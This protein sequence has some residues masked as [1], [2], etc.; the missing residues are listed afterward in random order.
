MT[1]W[2]GVLLPLSVAAL[3]SAPLPG[4]TQPNATPPATPSAGAPA[5][6]PEP[7][8]APAE[9]GTGVA[10]SAAQVQALPAGGGNR[11]EASADGESV[12]PWPIDVVDFGARGGRL[13]PETKVA[14]AFCTAAA[15][16]GGGSVE[17]LVAGGEVP[18]LLRPPAGQDGAN[19]FAVELSRSSAVGGGEWRGAACLLRRDAQ[20]RATESP[21]LVLYP[22]ESGYACAPFGGQVRVSERVEGVAVQVEVR[23]SDATLTTRTLERGLNDAPGG[24]WRFRGG[25][26]PLSQEAL[27]AC[28]SDGRGAR[29]AVVAKKT[30]LV[31]CEQ[32]QRLV[33]RPSG[34][35]PSR[36][37][38]NLE[39]DDGAH[40][41][42]AWD[43]QVGTRLARTVTLG[44]GVWRPF[45][46]SENY[47]APVPGT[48]GRP[49]LRAGWL[50]KEGEFGGLSGKLPFDPDPNP[51]SATTQY[52]YF[53]APSKRTLQEASSALGRPT[54]AG[55]SERSLGGTV[56]PEVIELFSILAEIA[57][58]QG[59]ARAMS[60]L[61]DRVTVLV[62]EDLTSTEM[63]ARLRRELGF[64]GPDIRLLPETCAVVRDMSFDDLAGAGESV[65]RALTA[66]LLAFGL[67]VMNV[68][69]AEFI[70]DGALRARLEARI[71]PALA[72]MKGLVIGLVTGREQLSREQSQLLLIELARADWSGLLDDAAPKEQRATL[73]GLELAF[74]VVGLCVEQGGCDA[75]EI[76]GLVRNPHAVF[77]QDPVCRDV[78]T[79]PATS[80]LPAILDAWPDLERFILVGLQVAVRG[81]DE[82]PVDTAQAAVDLLFDLL[83]R[84]IAAELDL[85]I[86]EEKGVLVQA[87]RNLQDPA[88]WV[89]WHLLPALVEVGTPV[90]GKAD[91]PGTEAGKAARE[92]AQEAQTLLASVLTAI[93]SQTA[94]PEVQALADLGVGAG[95][96]L[97][98]LKK[99][100]LP[101]PPR[102][103][104]EPEAAN[105]RQP[106]ILAG[107]LRARPP[108]GSSRSDVVA[109]VLEAARAA[110]EATSTELQARLLA[111]NGSLAALPVAS[112]QAGYRTAVGRWT[113]AAQTTQPDLLKPWS[114]A[115]L[116]AASAALGGAQ[117]QKAPGLA[118]PEALLT[119]FEACA[120]LCA[121]PDRATC[122]EQIALDLPKSGPLLVA[123]LR[124][125]A[126]TLSEE[127][128]R[129][130]DTSKRGTSR[131]EAADEKTASLRDA[132]RQVE[133]LIAATA[134]DEWQVGYDAMLHA[135][136]SRV[137]IARAVHK[138]RNGGP[139]QDSTITSDL[140]RLVLLRRQLPAV[141]EDVRSLVQGG[142]D[143]DGGA[144]VV[145]ASSLI[146]SSIE[147]GVL[148]ARSPWKDF[149]RPCDGIE[150]VNAC[151]R[152]I[153][154]KARK[155]ARL[156][157]TP[158]E[159]LRRTLPAKLRGPEHW[160]RLRRAAK[161]QTFRRPK[162]TRVATSMAKLSALLGAI[163]TYSATYVQ[164]DL[165]AEAARAA[166]K[167]AVTAL[168]K[169]STKRRHRA[170][171][172]I[173]SVGASA[174][175]GVAGAQFVFNHEFD[176]TPRPMYGQLLLPMGLALQRLPHQVAFTRPGGDDGYRRLS[177]RGGRNLGAGLH[178][179]VSA[180]DLGQFVA[181]APL[182]SCETEG[183]RS[184]FGGQLCGAGASQVAEPRWE[185]LFAL[186]GQVGL[187]VG[188]PEGPVLVGVD[189][190][191]AP[192]LFSASPE[193]RDVAGAFRIGGMLS[194][195]IPFF[196]FN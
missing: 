74:G 38:I 39:G 19:P 183:P 27:H 53:E 116:K 78:M 125:V 185:N 56:P 108:R 179:M 114:R 196:D 101:E 186:G 135:L 97:E 155:L 161:E 151:E 7:G 20:N 94:A 48:E 191:Y 36:T 174:G 104:G 45:L 189:F 85:R 50:G 24:L 146:F 129:A 13:A 11:C 153:E 120:T 68:R 166:R 136:R 150:D 142:L 165:D 25:H 137:R 194:F 73:C 60:V 99:L 98:A 43:R 82:D 170:A 17:V 167:D 152:A 51:A 16:L 130:S 123:E 83:Q 175:I 122:L 58:E 143:Q 10:V 106:E 159:D 178:L 154:E 65:Y 144:V 26:G 34:Q 88:D 158:G 77:E 121:T 177:F 63:T 64:A 86:R 100:L 57:V 31:A 52:V 112:R 127:L 145:A 96:D 8:D 75:G 107:R 92:A 118:I 61:S 14:E 156:A 33:V 195:Y 184:K 95:S 181:H 138:V 147:L 76:A 54:T 93:L 87:G 4:R 6:A 22:A 139:N 131:A 187:L 157:N 149:G 109:E 44:R 3:L 42:L 103:P 171:E 47:L 5:D 55:G 79:P 160:P 49:I 91:P 71:E 141:I 32:S 132:H 192:T 117:S 70:T 110:R 111:H 15:A 180:I 172:W 37:V 102:D 148:V 128:E 193:G 124:L 18:F 173:L 30:E 190:R 133:E 28:H 168:I 182:D 176:G 188:T 12:P 140:E 119:G 21:R 2:P 35:P 126:Q 46:W 169:A 164:A 134:T 105:P 59:R 81:P 67:Q 62:C 162:E 29:F 9:D 1:R 113:G 163:A 69:F 80:D 115:A 23:T 84:V 90:V 40:H 41:E 72:H 66:D 89:R